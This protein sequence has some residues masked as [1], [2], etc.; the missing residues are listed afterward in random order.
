MTPRENLNILFVRDSIS[1][2]E[3]YMNEMK[4]SYSEFMTDT[5]YHQEIAIPPELC[6]TIEYLKLLSLCGAGHNSFTESIAAEQMPL[7]DCIKNLEIADFCYPYKTSLIQF[8]DNI[9][10]DIEKE[11]SD[12][13]IQK[14]KIVIEIIRA[15]LERFIVI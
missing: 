12:D 11:V 5:R 7:N 2:L 9:F 15:D 4:L 10:F 8:I 1:D 13:N 14:I 6:Y 3:L